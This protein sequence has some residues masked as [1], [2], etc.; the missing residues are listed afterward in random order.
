MKLRVVEE[1][2]KYLVYIEELQLGCF[3]TFAEAAQYFNEVH[4][5]FEECA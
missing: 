3:D 5:V 4:G 2:G 1:N